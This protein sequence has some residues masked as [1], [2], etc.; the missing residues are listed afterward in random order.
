VK[1]HFLLIFLSTFIALTLRFFLIEDFRVVSDSMLPTLLEGDLIF[2]WKPVYNLHF[3]FS[4]YEIIRIQS[5]SRGDVV[6]FSIPDKPLETFV[7]RV[8][9]V[10]GDTLEIRNG[11]IQINGMALLQEKQS[12]DTWVETLDGKRWNV[13]KDAK[14]NFGPIDVPK[15]YFF[16]M[17]DNRHISWDSRTWGPIP[18]RCLKGKASLVWL[19]FGPLGIRWDRS[20][21]RVS[22]H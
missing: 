2:A 9:A 1:K 19:S 16:A 17:G 6:L 18:F 10:E 8:I 11:E 13:V 7:K 3:P 14:S 20:A 15:E 21:L 4:N 22:A 5:P 12:G